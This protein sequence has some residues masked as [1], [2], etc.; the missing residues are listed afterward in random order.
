MINPMKIRYPYQ[1]VRNTYKEEEDFTVY[2]EAADPSI[3]VFKGLYYLFPSMVGGF[4][5]SKD[6]VDW[7]FHAFQ[8]EIPIADYAPDACVIDDCLYITASK[9]VE[10]CPIFRSKDPLNEPF[11]KIDGHM[12]YWDPTFFQDDDGRLYFYWGCGN[13]EPIWGVELNKETFEPIGEPQAMIDSRTD[14]IGYE[15]FGENHVPP[16]SDEELQAQLEVMVEQTLQAY[17]DMKMDGHTV[18]EEAIRQQLAGMFTNRPY[19]EGAWVN[20]HKGR[21]YLQYA[22]PGTEFNVYGDGVYVSESPLGPYELAPS[23]P[24]SY[25]PGG[26]LNGAG[27]GSTFEDLRGQFWHTATNS[28]SVNENFE[29]RISLWKAGFDDDGDLYCDQRFGDWPLNLDKPSFSDPEW[30]LLSLDKNVTVSSGSDAQNVADENIRT[31]WQAGKDDLK[32][33][34]VLDL[35]EISQVNAVQINFADSQLAVQPDSALTVHE[36]EYSERIIDLSDHHTRW[37]LEYS[38]DGQE[39]S[40][41]KDASSVETDFSHD[42]VIDEA[43]IK[44]RFIKLTILEVPYHQAPCISGLRVFGHRPGPLP[45]M[46][47]QMKIDS[48]GDLDVDISWPSDEKASGYNILWGYKSDKLYHSYLVYRKNAQRIS[49]LIK[50]VPLFMRID[51]FNESGLVKGVIQQIR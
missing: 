25:K 30:M 39:F 42:Y 24:F 45:N 36:N 51:S 29:R 43:G 33:E 44:A 34:I 35:G 18:T 4:L 50:D 1:F 22:I 6:L 28:I 48:L 15:R 17:Q 11:E 37:R 26:F 9:R 3:V 38:L 49:A 46:V 14:E 23:N 13:T 16:H 41:L 10:N 47:E 19:I 40:V 12:P 20:K 5:T 21:Y 32:P 7:D 27:H 2:R 8:P 31:F